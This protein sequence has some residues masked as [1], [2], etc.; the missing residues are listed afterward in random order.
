VALV[1]DPWLPSQKTERDE[2]LLELAIS[3]TATAINDIASRGHSRLTVAIAGRPANCY[4][5]P[6]SPLFCEELLGRLAE[7]AGGSD[8]VV[9][10]AL[11]QVLE[12]APRGAR[13]IVVSPR[14]SDDPS[15]TG[16]SAELPIEPEDLAWVD[17]SNDE[18]G[19]LFTLS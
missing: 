3:L 2:G 11:A 18:L 10:D 7:L 8:H 9:A 17:T 13:L 6:A 19:S 12:A 4:C 16:S 14:P 5:G 15:L 1:L